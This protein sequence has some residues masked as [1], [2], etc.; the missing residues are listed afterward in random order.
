MGEEQEAEVGMVVILASVMLRRGCGQ[1]TRTGMGVIIVILSVDVARTMSTIPV[2][3]L[4]L[5]LLEN[6]RSIRLEF[7]GS[8]DLKEQMVLMALLDT[9]GWMQKRQRQER[10]ESRVRMQLH[11]SCSLLKKCRFGAEQ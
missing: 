5:V 10:K 3:T 9:L 1:H 7:Q 11:T 2:P 4:L 8:R 6:V